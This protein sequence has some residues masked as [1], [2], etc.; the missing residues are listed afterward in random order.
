[1]EYALPVVCTIPCLDQHLDTSDKPSSWWSGPSVCQIIVSWRI[2]H[3]ER[4]DAGSR[5]WSLSA[6]V[7]LIDCVPLS[8]TSRSTFIIY[9]R[10]EPEKA[11]E[12]VKARARGEENSIPLH[13]WG[14]STSTT[15]T[16]CLN[17]KYTLPRP[18][19]VIDANKDMGSMIKEYIKHEDHAIW[20]RQGGNNINNLMPQCVVPTPAAF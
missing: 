7:Q 13:T 6:M 17:D 8:W 19:L 14:A 2:F 5:V 12:R 10:T 9:L 3:W 1:M 11:L 4:E 20:T 16:G 18:V 15:R